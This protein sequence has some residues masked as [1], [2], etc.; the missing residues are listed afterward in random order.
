MESFPQCNVCAVVVD[1]RDVLMSVFI[2]VPRGEDA[3]VCAN[4]IISKLRGE[5]KFEIRT[6]SV[7]PTPGF[8]GL[9]ICVWVSLCVYWLWLYAYGCVCVCIFV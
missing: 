6:L 1:M 8:V 2:V 4:C 7:N 9:C 3:F 5:S